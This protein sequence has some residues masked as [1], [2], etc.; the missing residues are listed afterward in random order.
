MYEESPTLY[1]EQAKR[2][3]LVS[4]LDVYTTAEDIMTA[5]SKYGTIE[6]LR[7]NPEK[8]CTLLTFINRDDATR[9]KDGMHGASIGNSL[10]L[11]IT[12]S[13]AEDSSSPLSL[14][15]SRS[16]CKLHVPFLLHVNINI[17]PSGFFS[18]HC[19]VIRDK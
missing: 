16:L 8:S 14:Q 4:N 2:T 10:P 9:A 19:L 1:Q 11:C 18:H 6:S 17:Q 13:K 3:I 7:T 12:F 15:P 5:F